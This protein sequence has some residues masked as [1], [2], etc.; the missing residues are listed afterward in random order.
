VK[1][2]ILK[3]EKG[4][5]R[6][7]SLDKSYEMFYKKLKKLIDGFELE[8]LNKLLETY[9]SKDIDPG[10]GTDGVMNNE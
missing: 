2:A 9:I 4:T 7:K 10:D 3:H 8:R 1:K 5:G 6:I